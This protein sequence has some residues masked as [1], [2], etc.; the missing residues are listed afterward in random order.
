[1]GMAVQ[2]GAAKTP[3]QA[4]VWKL[5][6]RRQAVLGSVVSNGVLYGEGWGL[7]PERPCGPR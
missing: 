2:R 1:M 5:E 3:T 7:T 4:G 6:D